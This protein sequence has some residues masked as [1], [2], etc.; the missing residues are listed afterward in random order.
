M[1]KKGQDLAVGIVTVIFVVAVIVGLIA[2]ISGF[3]TVEPSHM[4]IMVKFSQI[5]GIFTT[6][7]NEYSGM[8]WTGMFTDV[9]SYD[10][11][12]RKAVIDLSGDN[13]AP[14]KDGQKIFATINVNYRVHKSEETITK[15]YT[16]IGP[17]NIIADRLNIDAIITEAF[18]QATVGYTAMEILEKRQEV[19]EIAIENI[20]KNFP[21]EY[22]EI[23]NIVVTNIAFSP[24]FADEIEKKQ[25]ALQTALKEQNNL[26]TV[27]YQ[28]QQEIEKY[29][30]EAEKIKLQAAQLTDLTVRQAWIAKWDGALPQYMLTNQANVDMLM[31]LPQ[32]TMVK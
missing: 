10:M 14:S 19:K 23:E 21:S 27:K 11:R 6:A 7:P 28:Q 24:A 25:I 5:Q 13:Y 26:E 2:L 18:K 16:N 31:Q 9:Y 32:S 3:D 1:N 17:D 4:G 29:K 15:L 22:F 12:T 20:K 8:K 30:A